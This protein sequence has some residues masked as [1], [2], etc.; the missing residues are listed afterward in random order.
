MQFSDQV[1]IVTGGGQ[2]IGR[3]IARAF[4]AEGASVVIADMDAEAG[5]ENRSF[6]E[7]VGQKAFFV[8]TDVSDT[9]SVKRLAEHTGARFGKINVLINNAGISIKS[10][11]LTDAPEIWDRVINTNLRGA[12]LCAKFCAPSMITAGGGSIVNIASTRALMSEPDSEAYAA[13]KGG[14]LALT[15]ALAVTLGPRG[16]RVNA[17][18]PGWIEVSDWQKNS[19]ATAPFHSAPDRAQHPA[20]RVGVPQDIAAACL[21]L[22]APQAGFITGTNLVVDG[23]MTVKMIYEE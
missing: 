2:G 4:A 3:A 17:V 16:V 21:Y 5:E 20:G 19:R 18:S 14:I 23:G 12:Y 15:H 11:F 10:D 1:V 7:N 8:P 22:A 13:S 9:E 6:I